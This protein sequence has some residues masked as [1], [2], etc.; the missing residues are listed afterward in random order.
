MVCFIAGAKACTRPSKA[1]SGVCSGASSVFILLKEFNIM[2]TATY[3]TDTI[4]LR[5][6]F[7]DYMYYGDLSAPTILPSGSHV[8][9]KYYSIDKEYGS[10]G[11]VLR[12][13]SFE[14]A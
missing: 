5:P 10:P 12:P 13:G 3:M 11:F 6:E 9:L 4:A 14:Y 7:R 8:V 2:L 1:A